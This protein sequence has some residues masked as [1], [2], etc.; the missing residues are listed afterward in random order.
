M[1]FL[2]IVFGIVG[3][4]FW[5]KNVYREGIVKSLLIVVILLC[6]WDWWEWWLVV[7]IRVF[8]RSNDFC[9]FW[10]ILFC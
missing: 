4:G 9:V 5:D 10:Y 3:K 2:G 8:G 1:C 7:S 6:F